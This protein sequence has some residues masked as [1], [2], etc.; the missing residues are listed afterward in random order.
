MSFST[1][2]PF[3]TTEEAD[4]S[5]FTHAN[6]YVEVGEKFATFSHED[7]ETRCH[8]YAIGDNQYLVVFSRQPFLVHT[9]DI[10]GEAIALAVKVC[11]EN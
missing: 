3:T 2:R 5:C 4:L 9:S 6:V 10:L 7:G 11:E 1:N 8:L